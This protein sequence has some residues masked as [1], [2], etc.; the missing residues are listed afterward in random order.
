MKK[1]LAII[2]SG[3]IRHESYAEQLKMIQ[4]IIAQFNSVKSLFYCVDLYFQTW[5]KTDKKIIDE[6]MKTELIYKLIIDDEPDQLLNGYYIHN[7]QK[8]YNVYCMFTG[9]YNIF[10]SFDKN[11]DYVCR[12]RNDLNIE[13][14]A[15]LWFYELQKNEN[16]YICPP[17][18]WMGND[19]I[20]DHFCICSKNV[21][22]KT[23]G[24]WNIDNLKTMFTTIHT[25]PETTLYLQAI[26]NNIDIIEI[27]PKVFNDYI[28]D[29]K[30]KFESVNKY[31]FPYIYF[32]ISLFKENGTYYKYTKKT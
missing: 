26:Y 32:Y 17:L 30:I 6:L 4:N 5:S 15:S 31:M 22:E 9:V 3:E 12:C 24:F 13:F 2:I 14:D 29:G 10:K 8:S 19:G 1:S 20:N 21:F 25:T 28:V 23:W 27:F 18:L 16:T 7:H 11:Y